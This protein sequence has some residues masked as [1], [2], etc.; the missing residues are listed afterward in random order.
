[1]FVNQIITH[2][3]RAKLHPGVLTA[4][5]R[6]IHVFTMQST[7]P[8]GIAPA[9]PA[10]PLAVKAGLE[11]FV[12]S[13]DQPWDRKRVAHLLRRTGFGAAPAD[14]ERF[15]GMSPEAAVDTLILEAIAAPL[16]QNPDWYG[17]PVP[18]QGTPQS[19]LDAFYVEN[20]AHRVEASHLW[21]KEM[22]KGGMREKLTLFWSNHFVTASNN[23]TL[24]TYAI[25]YLNLMRKEGL[26]NFKL[27]TQEMGLQ[28]SML[29]Y[30]NGV[31]NRKQGPNEN[32]AR[33]LLELFTM[34][35][36]NK[37]GQPNYTQEDIAE[38]ARAFTGW[39]V[40]NRV[41]DVVFNEVRFDDGEKTVFGR[42]GMWGYDN[43]IDIIFE[44]R[45]PEIAYFVCEK[46]YKFYVYQAPDPVIVSGLANILLDNNFYLVPV[47]E[48]LLHS[49]HFFDDAFIGARIKSPIEYHVGLVREA[50]T[51]VDDDVVRFLHNYSRNVG[52]YVLRPPNVAGWPEGQTWLSTGTMPLRWLYAGK[53]VAGDNNIPSSD[54]TVLA[55]AMSNPNDP[56][57]LA[58]EIADHMLP[59]P[60]DDTAYEELTAIMLDG[61]PDYEWTIDNDGANSRLAGYLSYL[62]QLPEYQLG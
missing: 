11:P 30:L 18:P 51:M 61:M 49:A 7:F 5:F 28:P 21:I 44:E 37:D 57:V 46:L 24:A 45:G 8:Q 17:I 56:Y 36:Q 53:F 6:H 62:A 39:Q 59:H 35:I 38:I 16:P 33:E 32:Y 12:P 1:M 13:Q 54:L 23:Y 4:L 58:R 9:Q 41:P 14:I 25:D 27:L 29:Q 2:P 15:I 48:A 55:N 26:G 47:L 40:L 31:Q 3:P 42:T 43:V 19:E 22:L 50:N 60:L 10:K 20:R 52:Q 34:G